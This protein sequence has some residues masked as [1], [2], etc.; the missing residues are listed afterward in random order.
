MPNEEWE[1]AWAI[2]EAPSGIR[3]GKVEY[4]K[5]IAQSVEIKFGDVKFVL[6]AIPFQAYRIFAEQ[7]ANWEWMVDKL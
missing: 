4:K 6:K 7:A 1:K 2:F 5:T 3:K